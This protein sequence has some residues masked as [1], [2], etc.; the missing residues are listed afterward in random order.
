MALSGVRS[1]FIKFRIGVCSRRECGQ[2]KCESI[3]A[4]I[5]RHERNRRKFESRHKKHTDSGKRRPNTCFR[6]RIEIAREKREVA[7]R[8]GRLGLHEYAFSFASLRGRVRFRRG[9]C[10]WK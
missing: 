7:E 2:V 8:D 6:C 1:V 10:G 9:G 5:E 3:F 4:Q